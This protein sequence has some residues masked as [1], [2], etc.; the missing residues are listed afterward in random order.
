MSVVKRALLLS[1]AERYFA[2][3]SSFATLAIISRILTPDEIGVSVIGMAVVAIAMA[4]R[5]FASTSYI[6]QH[7]A[8][9]D[10]AIR[11][12][13]SAMLFVTTLIAGALALLAPTLA[14]AYDEA[15]LAPYLYVASACLV[16]ELI[17]TL[18]I[19][20]MR[21]E[22][23]FG[24]V[25]IISIAGSATALVAS[26]GLALLGFSYMSLA[27]AWLAGTA[28]TATVALCLRPDFRMFK[29]ILSHWRDMVAFGGYNGATVFLYKAYE[30]LPYLLLGRV[31]SPHASAL[32]SRTVMI[33]QLPDKIFLSGA[34]SVVLS[35]FSADVRQGR[36]LKE[37]YLH[38]LGLVTAFQWPALMVLALLA[39]PVVHIVL[40]DQW[41]EVAPLVQIAAIAYLFSFSFELN[42]P[43]FVSLGAVRDI[44]LRALIVC[45]V[46][47]V[48]MTGA[49]LAGGLQAM[50]YSLIIIIPFQAFVSF[51]F[52]RHRVSLRWGELA[53]SLWR[54]AAVAAFSAA[55]PLVVLAA[56]GFR[57][58]LSIGQALI[59][60]ALSGVA[61]LGGLQAT[62]HPL[63]AE[64]MK[65]IPA[66]LRALPAPF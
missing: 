47:A 37:P 2:L 45:P 53:A 36:S 52:I 50:A 59:A 26:T 11:G 46:S 23:E 40:G 17:S 28:V 24:K 57:L 48:I 43:V 63:R 12:A 64:I 19:T 8:L 62:A 16:L 35:A 56:N 55:G 31:L 58:E 4:L 25:A 66:R 20:L 14:S 10:E 15:R 7:R 41:T 60:G 51:Q 33:C 5:E 29:P 38:A 65:A 44:F 30:A 61:W 18:I 9:T 1:T 54:S 32:F 6:I 22:M 21:R 39:H 49:A 13:F 3:V 27:W 34:A 42:Y